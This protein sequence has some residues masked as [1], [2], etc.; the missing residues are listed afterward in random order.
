MLNR[1]HHGRA[2][3]EIDAASNSAGRN[4]DSSRFSSAGL[5]EETEEP[6]FKLLEN[7]ET[8]QLSLQFVS[9]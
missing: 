3:L 6:V 4:Q 8:V 2:I 1:I 5:L 9:F 7:P